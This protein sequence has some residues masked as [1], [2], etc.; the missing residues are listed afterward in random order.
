MP[1]NHT[2]LE[3]R[4][5]D[6]ADE[7]RA[8]SRLRASEYSVPVLGLIFLKYADHRFA[9]A[10]RE[11]RAATVGTSRRGA[12]SPTP[13][14]YKARGV[15]Y[16]PAEARFQRLVDL[17]ESANVGRAI[18][19]AM[20]A[21]ED[22]NEALKD[23]LP[24]AY[25][26]F[27]NATLRELLRIFNGIPMDIEGDV[28]GKIY[29]YFLGKF[30]M[31]EGQ[32]GGEFFTPTSIVKLIVAVIEPYK[33]YILD[34]A[35]G[36]GGMFVQSAR[37]VE[38]HRGRSS[39]VAIYG[40]ERV[41]ETVRLCKM[42]LAVH[43]LEG[44]IRQG[45]TYYDALPLPKHDGFTGFDFVMAN[46]PF[47]VN[48]VDKERIKN[49]RLRYP[50]GIPTVDNA[51]YLWIQIF[52][53]ALNE[54]GRAGFVMANSASDARG[55]ELEL[56]KKLIQTGAVDVMIAVG[57]NF[58]YT[59]TLP[60]TLWFLDRGKT[61]TPNPSPSQGEG[62]G[63]RGRLPSP[64]QG[65]G[66]GVRVGVRGHDTVLFIDARQI[67]TQVDRAHREFTP[68]QI[69]FLADVVRLYRG[70]AV[71]TAHGSAG[72]LADHFPDGVYQDV[73]G[74]CKVAT[75]EEIEAQGWSLNPGRYVGVAA[76]VDEEEAD[77]AGR[78]EALHEEL[79][80]LNAEA[81]ELE[82]RIGENVMRILR[83]T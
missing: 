9:H 7:L 19:D 41:A 1:A 40:Q 25:L 33:G 23:V 37:F 81:H 29:E 82:A 60:C 32:K 16:L 70:H 34:P 77:F 62:P 72:L 52:Y 4:L 6:A 10:D 78:L 80:L 57:S 61:L 38:E 68:A 13:D 30:A 66:P 79:E 67:Y 26:R 31:A 48:R 51:N 36:S 35:A 49:D 55:S 56:R 20:K 65:E 17:P 69:E 11:L 27:E 44:E 28:F 21:I 64:S 42:N 43:G 59:V 14:H 39:D 8:N 76:R 83:E 12:S 15:L 50:F 47:N 2:H 3:Q 75:L 24:K 5:W 46:P 58:F 45:N 74:L 63:V 53:S 22:H 18:N 71:E 73:P 54:R